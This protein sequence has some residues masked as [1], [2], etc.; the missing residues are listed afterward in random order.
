MRAD[1][2]YIGAV[3][4]A[5]VV[6]MTA[7]GSYPIHRFH[8]PEHLY[9]Q[10]MTLHSNQPTQVLRYKMKQNEAGTYIVFAHGAFRFNPNGTR[11]ITILLNDYPLRSSYAPAINDESLSGNVQSCGTILELKADDVLALEMVQASR[12]DLDIEPMLSGF[13]IKRCE[14]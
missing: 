3:V 10:A 5:G 12:E 7:A 11:G 4:C 14:N 13:D 1:Y 8:R 2:V 6:I 9:P